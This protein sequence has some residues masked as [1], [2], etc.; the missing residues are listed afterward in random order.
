MPLIVT[1][2][3]KESTGAFLRRFSRVVQQSGILMRVRS[4]RYRARSASPRIEKKNAIYRMTR[5]KETD[6]LR[7]LGKIE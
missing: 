7:K 4:F 2:K 1:K 3:Q 6:K 5:R